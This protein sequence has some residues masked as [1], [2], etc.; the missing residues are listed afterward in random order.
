MKM[1]MKMKMKWLISGGPLRAS[2]VAAD[3]SPTQTIIA[4]EKISHRVVEVQ[5]VCVT[6]LYF[7][8]RWGFEEKACFDQSLLFPAR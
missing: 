4:R 7:G 6:V 2:P 5:S 1:E 3:G 8:R